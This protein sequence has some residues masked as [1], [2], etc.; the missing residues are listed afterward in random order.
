MKRVSKKRKKPKTVKE[1]ADRGNRQ[2]KGDTK[3]GRFFAPKGGARGRWGKR[4]R[5]GRRGDETK[6]RDAAESGG[7]RHLGG[8]SSPG[9][10]L[11]TKKK[12]WG[13]GEAT[14]G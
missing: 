12:L 7:T 11:G 9:Q 5:K 10:G 3:G 14:Q 2:I 1:T 8:G 13:G 4:S 6:G